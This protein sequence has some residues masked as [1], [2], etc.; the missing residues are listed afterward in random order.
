MDRGFILSFGKSKGYK[1]CDIAKLKE[2]INKGKY[3][4]TQSRKSQL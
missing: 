4:S 3:V 1:E 2:Q